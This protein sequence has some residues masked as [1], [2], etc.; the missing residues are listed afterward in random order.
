MEALKMHCKHKQR[1]GLHLFKRVQSFFFS[2]PGLQP[3]TYIERTV[4]VG[5][6]EVQAAG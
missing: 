4:L 1:P 2:C 3:T 6:D 5:V